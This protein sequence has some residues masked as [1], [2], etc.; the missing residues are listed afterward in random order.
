MPVKGRAH[1]KSLGDD[2]FTFSQ[3]FS[4]GKMWNTS[5]M[6]HGNYYTCDTKPIEERAV[7][8]GEIVVDESTVAPEF[9]L[10][11]EKVEKFKYLRGPKRIERISAEGHTYTYSEGGMSEY[12]SLDLPSRT[13]LTSEGSTN[14]STH[15]LK[16]NGRYRLLT[17]IEAE[18]LQGFPDDWTKFRKD[19]K[20]GKVVEVPARMRWF[21]MGNALV[22]NIV[23]RI[24]L[25]LKEIDE[26]FK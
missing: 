22:T 11:E 2:I 18:R 17:P 13:M 16:I 8:L 7:T 20:T 23:T 24:G 6:C 19:P 26:K 10:S 9:Y 14:R 21:F 5:V 15:L 12:D 3:T 4:D 25:E 1:C